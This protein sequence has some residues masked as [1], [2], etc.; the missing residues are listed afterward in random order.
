MNAPDFDVQA[1]P[2]VSNQAVSELPSEPPRRSV[3][4]LG[5]PGFESLSTLLADAGLQVRQAE[6]GAPISGS[7]WG[8]PEAGLV[9]N[10]LH[11]RLDTPVHSALHEA[12]HWLLMGETRRSA[13]HTDAG[14]TADEENAVCLLQILLADA[15]PPM[16]RLRMFEDMDAWGYSF[17]LGSSRAWF[18][19]D[20]DDARAAL[21][22]RLD[23]F[24]LASS[25]MQLLR[26]EVML[27]RHY[28]SDAENAP[29]A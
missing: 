15:M 26:I 27:G 22:E 13:L 9:G 19:H 17:R 25:V 3:M 28:Q 4:L 12:G 1:H 6:P 5:E 8:E 18:E 11:V 10:E 24:A 20:A 29:S 23:Q 21:A 14:G 2:E 16:T 7:H